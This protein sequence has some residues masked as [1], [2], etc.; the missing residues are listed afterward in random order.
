MVIAVLGDASIVDRVA[1]LA[2]NGSW[3]SSLR[4]KR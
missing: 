2:M 4:S 3:K 1:R